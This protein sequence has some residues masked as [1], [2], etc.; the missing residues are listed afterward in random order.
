[1][2]LP[3]VART[4]PAAAIVA[5]VGQLLRLGGL[6]M[7]TTLVICSLA[8]P[9]ADARASTDTVVLS[10]S[11]GAAASDRNSGSPSQPLRTIGRAIAIA[12]ANSGQG[13]PTTILVHPGVYRE[14]LHVAAAAGSSQAPITLV[15]SEPG[16]VI[17]SGADVW[18]RWRPASTPGVV[19]HSWPYR[20][21]LTP[22]PPGWA[23]SYGASQLR[24]FP[25]IRRREM[26][27]VD[28][29]RLRQVMSGVT[30]AR[31]PGTFFVSEDQGVVQA[32]LPVGVAL[33][34][35]RIEVSVRPVLLGIAYRHGVTV[36]NIAFR[37][38]NTPL[39]SGAVRVVQSSNIRLLHCS[40]TDNNWLGLTAIESSNVRI[41]GVTANRNGSGGIGA[42]AVDDLYV[43]NT[44]TSYNNWR[45]GYGWRM[46]SRPGVNDQDFID[47]ASG[48]KF[49]RL[50]DATFD[51]LR[52]VGNLAGGIWFDSD[53]KRVTVERSTF[54][55]NLTFGIFVEADEGPF[56]ITGNAVCSNETG[57]LIGNT[58]DGHL[59]GNLFSRNALGQVFV[60]GSNDARP[61]VDRDTGQ[62][63]AL[64]STHWSSNHNTFVTSGD[65][66][67]LAT[68]LD[69]GWDAFEGTLHSDWN[70]YF[71]GEDAHVFRVARGIRL[72]LPDWQRR[73]GLDRSSVANRRGLSCALPDSR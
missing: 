36:R 52:S 64:V 56:A 25:V 1:M 67:A 46:F 37:D 38:A 61:I 41:E 2:L 63:V 28:G 44:Q 33:Q 48:Q 16:G 20:W 35:A 73:S 60:A 68:T 29:E 11:Q 3:M 70:R 45:G 15:G 57:V 72:T 69:S 5:N 18:R 51:R 65:Q 27:L 55:D 53:S 39:Q 58:M 54:A 66:H 17:V 23:D 7:T 34:S 21:G 42:Y 43:G 6:L 31:K 4:P 47:F 62:T 22:L 9:P 12:E 71:Y 14:E 50:R 30:M 19:Q 10:V 40:F 24:R 49:F 13:V 26:V 59:L 32:H 8:G